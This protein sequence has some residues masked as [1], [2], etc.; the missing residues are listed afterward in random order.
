MHTLLGGFQ[1]YRAPRWSDTK[2]KQAAAD[3]VGSAGTDAGDWNVFYMY[4]HNAD[5]AANRDSVPVTMAAIK[6]VPSQCV[7]T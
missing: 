3:G 1:P 2:G 7:C 5:Y 6:S 4:L